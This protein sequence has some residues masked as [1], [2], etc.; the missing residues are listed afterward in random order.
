[1]RFTC[2]RHA[3]RIGAAAVTL[4]AACTARPT[5][6]TPLALDVTPRVELPAARVLAGRPVLVRYRW[7]TGPA[8][9]PPALPLRVFAHFVDSAGALL[10]S[11][12]HAPTPP[13]A[14]WRADAEYAYER[15]VFTAHMFPGRLRLRVGLFDPAGGQRARL[16]APDDGQLAIPVAQLDVE[17]TPAPRP[18]FFAG[19]QPPWGDPGEPFSV[20]HCMERE[21]LVSLPATSRESMLFV[22]GRRRRG[23]RG[24]AMGV[25]VTLGSSANLL[26]PSESDGEPFV[27]VLAVRARD[28]G[29]SDFVDARF[30]PSAAPPGSGRTMCVSDVAL[31]PL[32]E[33]SPDLRRFAGTGR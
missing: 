12:D 3:F 23:A 11:D 27:H 15:V 26:A 18:L 17:R 14:A 19:W 29:G 7:T 1:M 20:Y 2:R 22:R 32:D 30:Q 21:A 31:V 9:R 16:Q 8:Y 25:R 5:R 4:L 24:G 33:M 10:V 28:A 6:T 13:L